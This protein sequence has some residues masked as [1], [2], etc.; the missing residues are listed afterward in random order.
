MKD[1]FGQKSKIY[2]HTKSNLVRF[3]VPSS[4]FED[5][6]RDIVGDGF[7]SLLTIFDCFTRWPEAFRDMTAQTV[8]KT[9]VGQYVP[10]PI[11]FRC[12]F[13]TYDRPRHKILI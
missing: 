5:L 8:A 3:N 12:S 7:T 9:F 11:S 6:H 1:I 2:W 4:R 13:S 10:V